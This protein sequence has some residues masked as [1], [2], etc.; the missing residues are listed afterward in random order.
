LRRHACTGAAPSEGY[1][2][3]PWTDEEEFETKIYFDK[4]WDTVGNAALEL[5][6]GK[7]HY[8]LRKALSD[9]RLGLIEKWRQAKRDGKA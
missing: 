1:V 8:E 2:S 6:K 4:E 5:A 9:A 3:D 7:S